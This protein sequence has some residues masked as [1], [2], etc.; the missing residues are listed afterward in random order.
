MMQPNIEVRG[1]HGHLNPAVPSRH[2]KQ[3]NQMSLSGSN[4]TVWALTGVYVFL[5]NSIDPFWLFLWLHRACIR[6]QLKSIVVWLLESETSVC[7]VI[8]GCRELDRRINI[9]CSNK[10][11]VHVFMEYLIGN[12]FSKPNKLVITFLQMHFTYDYKTWLQDIPVLVM[13]SL[14]GHRLHQHTQ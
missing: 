4:C 9:A 1:V 5:H 11:Y 8:C 14:G 3:Y 6:G 12:N 13:M 10:S 2:W 7:I